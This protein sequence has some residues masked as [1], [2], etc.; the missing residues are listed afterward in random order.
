MR[1]DLINKFLYNHTKELPKLKKIILNFGSKTTGM[2]NLAANLLALELI[3]NQKGILTTTKHSN[4]ILKIRKG[5]PTGCKVTLRGSN[6][7]HFLSKTLIEIFPK[8]KDFKGLTLT[9]KM[10]KNV[11]SYE[12]HETFSFHELEEHYYLFHNLPKLDVTVVTDSKI[13][14]ELVFILKSLQIPFKRNN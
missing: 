6:M 7:F 11:F 12:L 10:K 2:K 8:V 14:E 4:I 1:H 3:T 9:K 13:K 5:N